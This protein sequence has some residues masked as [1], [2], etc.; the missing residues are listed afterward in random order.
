MNAHT[1]VVF[2]Y[3]RVSMEATNSIFEPDLQMLLDAEAV[4]ARDSTGACALL[5]ACQLLHNL[6]SLRGTSGFLLEFWFSQPWK[7]SHK[8]RA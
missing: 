6:S 2:F 5:E 1:Q 7:L 4:A 3:G 8:S